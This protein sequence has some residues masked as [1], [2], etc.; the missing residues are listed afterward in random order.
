[1]ST[2]GVLSEQEF[3]SAVETLRKLAPCDELAAL[4]PSGPAT[5]YTT[6]V[7]IWMMILQRLGGGQ[8]LDAV[9]KEVL[10]HSAGLL[11][12]NK[13]VREKRLS[14]STGAYSD[15]RMRLRLE[16]VEWLAE[17]VSH[18]LI[19]VSPPA[20]NQRQAR[21]SCQTGWSPVETPPSVLGSAP[22]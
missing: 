5:V 15:A 14:E 22:A 6:L 18:S 13:R 3:L 9:V 8:S 2:D 19:A 17:R 20:F 4:Q 11:P 1:M 12:D 21:L 10:S 7:T 16:T